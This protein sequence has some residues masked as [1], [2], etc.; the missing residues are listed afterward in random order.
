[1]AGITV[2]TS[3]GATTEVAHSGEEADA[4]VGDGGGTMDLWSS[5]DQNIIDTLSGTYTN[6]SSFSI[7]KAILSSGFGGG[8]TSEVDMGINA[9]AKPLTADG[10]PMSGRASIEIGDTKIKSETVTGGFTIS[11]G[12]P[13][14]TILGQSVSSKTQSLVFTPTIAALS[15]VKDNLGGSANFGTIKY[16]AIDGT[17]TEYDGTPVPNVAVTGEGHGTVTDENGY[18]KM[19]APGGTTVDLNALA[20]T[21]SFTLTPSAGATLTEDISFPRLVVEVLDG[22]FEPIQNAPVQ[23]DDGTEY[24]GENGQVSIGRAT[25]KDYYINVMDRF[26]IQNYTVQDAG[27]EYT[28]QLAPG[29]PFGPNPEVEAGSL[30]LKVIDGENGKSIENLEATVVGEGSLSLSGEQGEIKL[31][32][33]EVGQQATVLIGTEDNRYESDV[34]VLQVPQSGDVRGTVEMERS[35]T[36]STY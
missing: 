23:I 36:S 16:G 4:T 10:K 2:E 14:G 27:E 7:P 26:E 6:D 19:Q 17:V 24:T 29:Q 13:A 18:Y 3:F 1:M 25:L 21:Y 31:L 8:K 22:N 9:S 11:S 30:T 5:S 20:G 12:P 32:S 33:K 28:V 34:V 35:R 15:I